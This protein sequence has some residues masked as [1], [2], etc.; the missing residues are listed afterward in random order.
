ME[1][2]YA[3]KDRG[4]LVY[5]ESKIFS[6]E[7]FLINVYDD[8]EDHVVT[9][10]VYGMDSQDQL[11]LQY[12]YHDFDGLFRFNAELMNPN[13]KE[14]RFH[15]VAERISTVNVGKQK[16]LKLIPE[17]TDE[18][19]M[20][21]VYETVRKIPTGRMDLKER[22]RLREA[23]DK[24]DNLRKVNIKKKRQAG[25]EKFLRHI[26][27]LRH[28][29]VRLQQELEDKLASERQQRVEIKQA[30]AKDNEEQDKIEKER[31]RLRNKQVDIKEE[32]TEEQDAEDYRQLRT[33]WKMR[34]AEKAKAIAEANVR[35]EKDDAER[36]HQDELNRQH[37]EEI[38]N[39]RQSM[40]DSRDARVERK[41]G[42][43]LRRVLEVK[44]DQ[45]RSAKMRRERNDEFI[46]ILHDLRK[47]V[48]EAQLKRTKER[49]EVVAAVQ[50]MSQSYNE[51]RA[52]PK[53]EKTKGKNKKVE[54]KEVKDAKKAKG[55]DKD[56]TAIDPKAA[57][58]DRVLDAVEAKMQAEMA[59]L[60]RRAKVQ[61]T[62]LKRIKA[63]KDVREKKVNDHMGEVRET[64]RKRLSMKEQKANERRIIQNQKAAEQQ[65]A[66]EKR[67]RDLERLQR[68]RSDNIQKKERE[69]L[70]RMAAMAVKVS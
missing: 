57:E 56:K 48:F 55:K 13:R 6:G 43:Q 38:Q 66:E 7:L 63:L 8:T 61:R 35:K 10:E 11:H 18:Q 52:I 68:M 9:F 5:Q 42:M 23:M 47:P 58:T 19:P 37:S 4:P 62:R 46:R 1:E 29:E 59:E 25:R 39:K 22:Q 60:N 16:Q 28:E 45:L 15:W 44:A 70:A 32:R 26:K 14:G 34:D 50:K 20:L 65:V 24:L 69:R 51:K 64:Y 12:K 3:D 30:T 67:N 41:N 54:P 31:Q 2:S 40:W 27:W 17:P 49:L 36:R 53:K 21:P 33:R